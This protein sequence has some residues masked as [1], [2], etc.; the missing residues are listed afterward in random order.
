MRDGRSACR[1][2]DKPGVPIRQCVPAANGLEN[3]V[4]R[5]VYSNSRCYESRLW[6]ACRIITDGTYI[7]P[8]VGHVIARGGQYTAHQRI[9]LHRESCTSGGSGGAASGGGTPAL[10]PVCGIGP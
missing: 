7:H 6:C 1:D 5:I 9:M 8:T 10:C 2:T 3:S 4:Q